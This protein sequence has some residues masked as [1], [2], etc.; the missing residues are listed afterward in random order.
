MNKVVKY[1]RVPVKNQK[2][3]LEEQQRE[4]MQYAEEKGFEVAEL[5]MLCKSRREIEQL[6]GLYVDEGIIPKIYM[7]YK[8]AFFI[9]LDEAKQGMFNQILIKDINDF[10]K[11]LTFNIGEGFG[12]VDPIEEIKELREYGVNIYFEKENI[13]SIDEKT[14]TEEL[15]KV[16]KSKFINKTI[17]IWKKLKQNQ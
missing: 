10:M 5:G 13:N 3:I 17:K 9:M 14:M 2:K 16:S 15:I 11:A 1:V 7:N 6:N 12:M 8:D 4:L